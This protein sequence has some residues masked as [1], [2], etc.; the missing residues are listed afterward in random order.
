MTEMLYY[1]YEGNFRT[2]CDAEILQCVFLD[3]QEEEDPKTTPTGTTTT[4]TTT[5]DD[6][7]DN[8]H[9]NNNNTTTQK[10]QLALNQ[11]VMHAQGGGQPTDRGIIYTTNGD[12][13]TVVVNVTKV[14]LDRQSKLAIHTGTIDTAHTA[15]TTT[16]TAIMAVGDKVKVVVDKEHRLILSECHTAGHVVDAAM[17]KCGMLPGMETSKAYHL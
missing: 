4:S 8:N 5:L 15:P 7:D 10:V 9:N 17:A 13:T 16:T 12:N 1:T 14:L 11:T 6:H 3:P 2:E